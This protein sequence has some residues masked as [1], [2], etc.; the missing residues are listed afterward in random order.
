MGD[1]TFL[2]EFEHLVLAAAL[3]LG[4]GAYGAALMREIEERTGRS[5]QAGSVYITVQRLEEKGL[6]RCTL[7]EPTEGRGGRPKRFVTP[8]PAGVRALADHREAMLRIW[9]GLEADLEGGR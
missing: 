8:T 4:E 7:G 3:R 9:D 6:V 5:V 1:R 2:G